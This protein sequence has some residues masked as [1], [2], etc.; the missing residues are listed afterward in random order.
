MTGRETPIYHKEEG[1]WRIVHVH[2]SGLPVTGAMKGSRV[3]NLK[4]ASKA[5][6]GPSAA[7]ATATAAQDDGG[8]VVRTFEPNHTIQPPPTTSSPS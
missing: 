1:A 6:A 5:N 3:V 8:F 4:L 2:Y 7:V